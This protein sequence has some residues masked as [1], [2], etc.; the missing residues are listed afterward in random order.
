MEAFGICHVKQYRGWRDTGV[1]F[2]FGD[3]TY[4]MPNRS[5]ASYC[6]GRSSAGVSKMA[7]GYWVDMVVSPFVSVGLECETPN[8]HAKELFKIQ[9]K[10][11]GTE[12]WR[13]NAVEI[14]VY[15]C[16]SWMQ[17]IETGL[18]YRM[19]QPHKVYS[20][21]GDD[22]AKKENAQKAPPS[23]VEELAGDAEK[24]TVDSDEQTDGQSIFNTEAKTVAPGSPSA[25]AKA[26]EREEEEK[27]AREE[28]ADALRRAQTIVASLEGVKVRVF[29]GRLFDLC[30]KKQYQNKFHKVVLSTQSCH[31]LKEDPLQQLLAPGAEVCVESPKF[32]HTIS[33]EQQA[34]YTAKVHEYAESK[35]LQPL[36]TGDPCDASTTVKDRSCPVPTF[37]YMVPIAKGD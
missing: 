27:R 15:N 1:A 9:S 16:L 22:S 35:G 24:L 13:H 11:T 5:M 6:E 28:H 7:K 37:S 31:L 12:Q 36:F 34:A 25:K 18:Q 19:I 33:Q 10:G 2:E 32:V 23:L 26:K 8:E 29:T 21:V 3:Q 4:T 14:A 20:G 17:E 30:R